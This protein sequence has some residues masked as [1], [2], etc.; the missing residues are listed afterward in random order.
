MLPCHR[1]PDSWRSTAARWG[2]ALAHRQLNRDSISDEEL[3]ATHR[4]IEQRRVLGPS[5]FHAAIEAMSGSC[6]SVRPRGRP[7]RAPAQWAAGEK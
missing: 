5:S 1:I 7:A 3:Q 4:Y 6:A 2:V